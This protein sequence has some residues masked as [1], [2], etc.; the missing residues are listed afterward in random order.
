[1]LFS[2]S[3]LISDMQN[4]NGHP[5]S[6]LTPTIGISYYG[7]VSLNIPPPQNKQLKKTQKNPHTYTHL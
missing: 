2:R 4:D 7:I 3:E 6:F 5:F 1:M